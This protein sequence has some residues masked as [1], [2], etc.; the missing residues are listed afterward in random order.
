MDSKEQPTVPKTPDTPS[1]AD[2]R[3]P[4]NDHFP[5]E[6]LGNFEI[7]G[8]IGR[9]GMGTVYE[10]WE[11]SLQRSVALKVLA[12]HVA[13]SK[14]AVMRF[15]R[16]AQ[17]A[18][19]LHH[20]HIVPI[21]AQGDE[22]GTYYYAMEFIDGPSLHSIIGRARD[23]RLGNNKTD[24]VDETIAL[25]RA[26]KVGD[27]GTPSGRSG[28]AGVDDSDETLLLSAAQDAAP[29]HFESIARH[30]ASIADALDYA[31]GQGVVH[32]DVK[33]HNLLLGTD[34]RMRIA[35]FGLAQVAE[36]PGVTVTGEML[37]SPLYMS[38][39]QILEGPGKVDHRT[40]IYSLGATMYEW[41]T[42][43]APYP[44]ETR[45][46]IIQRVTTA[47]PVP[48]HSLDPRIPTDLETVC[49]KAIQRER[50]RR[51]QSAGAFRDD[52]RRF[53][54]NRP[55]KARRTSLA[56]RVAKFVRRNQLAMLGGLAAAV[57][58]ILSWAL[59]NSQR[60][61]RSHTADAVE[62]RKDKERLLERLSQ[63]T[64]V[65]FGGTLGMAEAAIEG[66]LETGQTV[67]SFF[68]GDSGSGD[69]AAAGAPHGIA[70]RALN[71][72]YDDVKP[73]GWPETQGTEECSGA[74]LE[75][76]GAR[77]ADP[78]GARRLV[79][80]CLPSLADNFAVR[81]LSVLLYGRLQRYDAMLDEAR[82]LAEL[83]L[84]DARPHLW[85]GLAE[86]LLGHFDESIEALDRAKQLD[87]ALPW[88]ETL[89]ALALIQVSRPTDAV[90]DLAG[91]LAR[92][93]DLPV[94]VLARAAAHA[95]VGNLAS[96]V[97][98][99]STVIQ[100]EPG[101]AAVLALR[102]DHHMRLGDY[103]AAIGDYEQAMSITGNTPALFGRLMGA[104][105]AQ[106]N[107][108]KIQNARAPRADDA[109]SQPVDGV[110]ELP[111]QN[112]FSRYVW[113]GIPEQ[114]QGDSQ[115]P[116]VEPD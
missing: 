111:V 50:H 61:I 87:Q 31:H 10:A 80:Q 57:V 47:E 114:Q 115:A 70:Q 9:G 43:Q 95:T 38:P 88:A 35:D 82:R 59:H 63:S 85:V 62:A 5:R 7:R 109:A 77:D 68:T 56:V 8:E 17:A 66:L 99:L 11:P 29:G 33:P 30:L 102:G 84:D 20:M 69:I 94:A 42:L 97:A 98:D 90:I 81:Q 100:I 89:R 72:L 106:I 40:D 37:G 1:V 21:F 78:S 53:L 19:K 75:A 79:D 45:E 58:L 44:G 49:L 48:P 54:D 2:T 104:K 28:R 65:E 23:Q 12:G 116:D 92:A 76:A 91:A 64:P 112:W 4:S 27:S 25:A 52:L 18:A 15:H 22:N 67:T 55:I 107:A 32:R 3:V 14:T 36:Q 60:Q 96:A 24:D 6:V 46:Q 86:L 41:L 16:E 103:D 110:P 74:V 13:S 73:R 51:Y 93:P 105:M 101:N 34:G 83:R 113:P 108:E 71:D 39:E 26:H